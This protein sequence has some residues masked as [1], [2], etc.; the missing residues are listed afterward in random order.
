MRKKI[1]KKSKKSFKK[2]EKIEKIRK[3]SKKI[4]KNEKNKISH[5]LADAIASALITHTF[6]PS[7]RSQWGCRNSN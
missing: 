3:K 1:E 4:E 7:P 5:T 6:A 2:S